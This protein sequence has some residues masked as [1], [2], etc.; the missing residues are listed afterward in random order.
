MPR[1]EQYSSKRGVGA[2]IAPRSTPG[3][4]NIRPSESMGTS[5]VDSLVNSGIQRK[6][7]IGEERAFQQLAKQVSQFRVP[8]H[9]IALADIIKSL[10]AYEAMELSVGTS[11][12]RYVSRGNPLF[13]Q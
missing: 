7:H 8:D 4:A 12:E 6:H 9:S 1:V 10:N 3:S 13:D 11:E 5:S 2:S